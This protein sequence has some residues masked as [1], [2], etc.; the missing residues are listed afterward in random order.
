MSRGILRADIWKLADM[1][2]RKILTRAVEMRDIAGDFVVF[3]QI[4]SAGLPQAGERYTQ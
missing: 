4:R 1:A 2:T 3:N